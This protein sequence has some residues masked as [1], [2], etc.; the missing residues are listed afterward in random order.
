MAAVESCAV[1]A[2]PFLC[3]FA[4]YGFE[5]MPVRERH[6]EWWFTTWHRLLMARDHAAGAAHVREHHEKLVTRHVW[7]S[8]EGLIGHCP[9]R[10]KD[11]G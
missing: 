9:K 3:V 5:S 11:E 4:R 2:R 1:V 10:M 7:V 8:R 6:L